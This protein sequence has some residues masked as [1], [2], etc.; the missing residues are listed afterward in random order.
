MTKYMEH[1]F[2]K[3]ISDFILLSKSAVRILFDVE[4]NEELFDESKYP[5]LGKDG[6]STP[7][8]FLPT[9][10]ERMA[11][12]F[13]RFPGRYKINLEKLKKTMMNS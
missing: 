7:A 4:V 13:L 9:G 3:Q 12:H 11:K 8:C 6:K 1:L 10:I 2:S 5:F